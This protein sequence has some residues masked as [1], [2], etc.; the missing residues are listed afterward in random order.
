MI[1]SSTS[2]STGL[3]PEY[4]YDQSQNA[5]IHAVP[6]HDILCKVEPPPELACN[7]WFWLLGLTCFPRTRTQHRGTRTRTRM[8]SRQPFVSAGSSE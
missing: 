8:R 4:E 2:T 6:G 3:R 1:L 7:A 5:G